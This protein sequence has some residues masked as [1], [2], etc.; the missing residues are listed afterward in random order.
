[1]SHPNKI[2]G[3]RA[4]VKVRER[5]QSEG[6]ESERVPNSGQ[7]KN[8][9]FAGAQLAG[10]V[11]TQVVGRFLRLEVKRRK[12]NAGYRSVVDWLLGND[13][14]VL[15]RDNADGVICMTLTT[16][17]DLLRRADPKHTTPRPP[18][19]ETEHDVAVP[20]TLEWE[21]LHGSSD[22]G[23]HGNGSDPRDECPETRPNDG[24]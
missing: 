19:P 23:G 16:F 9:S 6:Y 8:A 24:D 7:N 11:R 4:E 13:A 21:A 10:D 14:L 15:H 3:Y 12:N 1:M 2:R 20:I 17:F 5:F 18:A 22:R